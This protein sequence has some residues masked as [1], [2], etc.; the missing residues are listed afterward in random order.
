MGRSNSLAN[1]KARSKAGIA[2][3]F[4]RCET[5]ALVIPTRSANALTENLFLSRAL[6]S[7]R[8]SFSQ[9]PRFFIV[10]IIDHFCIAGYTPQK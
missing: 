7:S 3:E 9:S 1:L 4:S 2:L 10:E 5:P 8:R 6:S